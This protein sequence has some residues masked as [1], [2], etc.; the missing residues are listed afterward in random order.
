MDQLCSIC[1][2]NTYKYKCPACGSKTCSIE[3]VKRHKKQTECSGIAD[4]TKFV[5]RKELSSDTT[6]LNRDYNFLLNL[7]RRIQVG[8]DDARS[9]AK[10]VFKRKFNNP[11]L[12]KNKRFKSTIAEQ[13]DKRIAII[14]KY[15][16]HMNQNY[17]TKRQNTLVIQ[18]PPGMS[19]SNSNKTGYDKKSG[20]FTWTVEWILLGNDGEEKA[21]FLSYRLKEHLIISEALPMNIINNKND[22]ENNI[23]KDQLFFYFDN[24]INF[25]NTKYSMFEVDKTKTIADTLQDRMVLEYPTFY[26]ST[27]QDAI[28]DYIIQAQDIDSVISESK[29]T[30]DA[31][32]ESGDSAVH[33]GSD[34]DADD[35]SSSTSDSDADSDSDS[36][37]DD[38]ESSSAE[39]S[40]DDDD[41]APEESS[42]KEPVHSTFN[43]TSAQ[44]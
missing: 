21:K 41:G 43:E 35:D 3:C 42:S 9:N 24:V 36:D 1:H 13:S 29:L 18:L 17:T 30:D 14:E 39:E 16:P 11:N 4:H 44:D 22:A 6:H 31:Q 40:D 15:F 34:L 28:K 20:S 12:A 23:E 7:D 38:E 33:P 37:S 5:P 8:K 25:K 19:R 26:I 32:K 10:N 2:I 27:S